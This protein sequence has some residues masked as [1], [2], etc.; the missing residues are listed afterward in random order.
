MFKRR[1]LLL[2]FIFSVFFLRNLNYLCIQ[3]NLKQNI[4]N[5][6]DN[7]NVSKL[8]EKHSLKN[9]LQT[10]DIEKYISKAMN[11]SSK[12]ISE[13]DELIQ[14]S[15]EKLKTNGN[16][17]EKELIKQ[18][19][20]YQNRINFLELQPETETVIDEITKI[21]ILITNLQ[22][23]LTDYLNYTGPE[24]YD[25]SE[26]FYG[27][28]TYA[29]ASDPTALLSLSFPAAHAAI[30]SYFSE[31]GYILA[32]ELLTYMKSNTDFDSI[33]R[34]VNS[35]V[36][37]NSKKFQDLVYVSSQRGSGE[38]E[39]SSDVSNQD[40]YMA[41]HNF[42]YSKSINNTAIVL[43]DR[44]DF[45]F[46]T[47]YDDYVTQAAV[48]MM[49]TAQGKGLLIPFY[50]IVEYSN[51]KNITNNSN[52]LTF[53]T[54]DW[55]Y[56]EVASTLG[57][58]ETVIF[59]VT[60]N[61]SGYRNIQTFGYND[62]YL[63]LQTVTGVDLASNDDGGYEKNAFL[64]YYFSAGITYRLVLKFYSSLSLGNVRTA[65]TPSSYTNFNNINSLE[66][67][68]SF[69][70]TYYKKVEVNN[71][72]GRVSMFTLKPA[73]SSVYSI[74]TTKKDN[75]IDTYLIMI[76]PRRADADR[77]D[78]KPEYLKS[79]IVNDDGGEN[80]QAK[81]N[82]GKHDNNVPYLIIASTYS[83]G[84]SGNFYITV[85]GLDTSHFIFL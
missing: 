7:G 68:K 69:F 62:A 37:K 54:S 41:I 53:P 26:S 10:S 40:L 14:R 17:V 20:N 84:I 34:P 47:S 1:F 6:I 12:E 36:V 61:V 18:I 73:T 24:N 44:Y 23:M 9:Q 81:I 21:K 78:S 80:L 71:E 65:I 83:S 48:N 3:S 56:N 85:S 25:K 64:N 60:F 39:S 58:A 32:A 28:Q 38:F 30:V 55:K 27:I 42:N 4:E 35:D 77:Y 63:T 22:M 43:T 50:I 45:E 16:S 52:V 15:E 76:D 72:A 31:K 51:D 5:G 8:K 66:R 67:T 49:A 33:Y 57:K 19:E 75:Y 59:N 46:K 13:F 70:K 74:Q 2:I 11:F 79:C 82:A 29:V